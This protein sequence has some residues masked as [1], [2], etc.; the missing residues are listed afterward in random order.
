MCIWKLAI[1]LARLTPAVTWNSP[2]SMLVNTH[3]VGCVTACVG[4][5]TVKL[6]M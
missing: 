6:S 3:T 4:V 1:Q 2:V 5:V